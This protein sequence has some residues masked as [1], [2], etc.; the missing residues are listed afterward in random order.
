MDSAIIRKLR[1]AQDLKGAIINA[2]EKFHKEFS[3]M[4]GSNE[5]GTSLEGS[6]DW[7][8]VFVNSKADI[9]RFGTRA[10]DCSNEKTILWFA[11]PKK[12]SSIKTDITRDKGWDTI[13]NRG[14]AGVSM[15][16]IDDTWSAFRVRP[17]GKSTATNQTSDAS[18]KAA[19]GKNWEGWFNQIDKV[20][21]KELSHQELAA[22][23]AKEYKVDSWWSQMI[24]NTYEQHIGRR[25]KHQRSDGYQ[26]SVSKTLII[27]LS[28]A[29]KAFSEESIRRKWLKDP[30]FEISTSRQ[31]KSLRAL[32]VDGKTRISVDFYAKGEEKT[33]VVVQHLKIPSSKACEEMK[34]YWKENIASLEKS[35][36]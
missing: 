22:M 20:N 1:F 26:A 21:G 33:Q 30:G 12:S 6:Q 31:N 11:Y 14:W 9:D 5:I 17:Q 3:D 7:I 36:S 4:A 13:H 15:I 23:I 16:S 10:M 2:P 25:K 8:L 24:T 34:I 18:V 19:T 29:F 27:P 32:W 28:K 35:L